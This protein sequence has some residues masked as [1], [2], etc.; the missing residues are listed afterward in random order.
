L[1]I[2]GWCSTDEVGI[3]CYSVRSAWDLWRGT[4]G[5]RVG[6][7]VLVAALTHPDMV[8]IVRGHGLR[9]VP[10][11]I[12]PQSLAPHPA[13]LEAALTPRALIENLM[14]RGPDASQATSSITV[15][16]PHAG[17]SPPTRARLLMSG[18]VSLRSG[19]T[20]HWTRAGITS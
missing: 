13:A 17:D 7:E 15:I 18:V 20:K 14:K 3:V 10:V 16:E 1:E 11:D 19:E 4:R 5:L 12:D 9:A 8:R 6:D 2:L